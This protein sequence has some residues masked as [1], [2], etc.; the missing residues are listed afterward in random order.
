MEQEA[1]RETQYARSLNI[2]LTNEKMQV[3]ELK[4]ALLG[5]LSISKFQHVVSIDFYLQVIALY[6]PYLSLM[7]S[8]QLF[9]LTLLTYC[10]I[11]VLQNMLRMGHCQHHSKIVCK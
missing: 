7:F 1:K 2:N 8:P 5:H 3:S 10:Q 11:N 4:N 6:L 9:A